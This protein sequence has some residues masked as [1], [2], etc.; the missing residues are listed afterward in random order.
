MVSMPMLDVRDTLLLLPMA[1]SG[2]S[3][4][5][6]PIF[7]C[8]CLSS[9]LPK[10]NKARNSYFLE[11]VGKAASLIFSKRGKNGKNLKSHIIS[12]SWESILEQAQCK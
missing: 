5:P 10:Q 6:L 8:L 1:I 4:L 12:E 9:W 3:N 11:Q 7:N 2:T